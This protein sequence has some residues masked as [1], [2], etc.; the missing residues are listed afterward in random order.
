MIFLDVFI[1]TAVVLPTGYLLFIKPCFEKSFSHGFNV[2]RMTEFRSCYHSL[3]TDVDY[4]FNLTTPISNEC[5]PCNFKSSN[6]GPNS[7]PHDVIAAKSSGNPYNM[8]IF[9]RSLRQSGAK[10][11]VIFFVTDNAMTSMSQDTRRYAEKCGAQFIN[12]HRQRSFGDDVCSEAYFHMYR[13]LQ[14]NRHQINRFIE[15]DMYDTFFQGD[16]FTP[17][18]P[19]LHMVIEPGYWDDQN[20]RW[21]NRCGGNLPVKQK[22]INGGFYGGNAENVF[23]MLRVF[24][25]HFEIG[26]DIMDQ[27]CFNLWIYGGLFERNG[28]HVNLTVNTAVTHMALEIMHR[29][30]PLGNISTYYRPDI[31]AMIMH[32]THWFCDLMRTIKAACPPPPGDF[33]NYQGRCKRNY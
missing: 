5:E 17:F 7:D 23:D 11:S 15:I 32:Q 4:I 8:I 20:I 21:M 33:S 22:T 28:V 14:L 25:S 9:L 31:R 1:P 3:Y 18:L 19:K 24:C 2:L 29:K 12:Y 6:Y 27:G 30:E 13:F 26:H 16:P 10:C